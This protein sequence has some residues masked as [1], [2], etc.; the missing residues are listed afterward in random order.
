ML[1]R[2]IDFQ[3]EQ[4]R[5]YVAVSFHTFS[6]IDYYIYQD[7]RDDLLELKFVFSVFNNVRYLTRQEYLTLP[8]RTMY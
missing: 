4:L 3:P 5:D 8:L 7:D 2:N 6:G 1:Y